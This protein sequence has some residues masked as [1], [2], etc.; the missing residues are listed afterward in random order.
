MDIPHSL[1]YNHL[2]K[3]STWENPLLLTIAPLF[4]LLIK[5]NIKSSIMEIYKRREGGK[6]P[7]PQIKRN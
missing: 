5:K 7:E 2:F 6:E 4:I 1:P 3:K